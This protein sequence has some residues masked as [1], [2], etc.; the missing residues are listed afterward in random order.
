[1]A[2]VDECLR[3]LHANPSDRPVRRTMAGALASAGRPAQA[4]RVLE[5][6]LGEDPRDLAAWREKAR[7]QRASGDVEG[8][9]ASLR[10]ITELSPDDR[11]AW[12]ELYQLHDLRGDL[13]GA[14]LALRRVTDGGDS[15]LPEVPIAEL[16]LAQG[17]L[18]ERL[19]RWEEAEA[20]LGRIPPESPQA[21]RASLHRAR[22]ACARGDA[23]AAM[24]HLAPWV[25]RIGSIDTAERSGFRALYA[26]LLEHAGRPEEAQQVYDA[27]CTEDPS[28]AEA[29]E[30]A[31]RLRIAAGL[32]P[33][34]REIAR[35]ASGR[36][37]I[38]EA[39]ALLWAEAESGSGDLPSAQSVV[40]SALERFPRSVPL[41]LRLGEI[42]GARSDWRLASE[43]YSTALEIGGP[44]GDLLL[45]L[46]TAREKAGDA[47]G[48][49]AAY[50]QASSLAPT[51][52]RAWT[53][54]GSLL[55]ATGRPEEAAAA[56]DRALATDPECDAARE[57]KKAAERD[58]RMR[59]IEA[60]A[61]AALR[62]EGRRRTPV[63]KH[64]LFV[65]LHV[66]FDLLDPVL[67]AMARA[68][69]L[70][71]ASLSAEAIDQLEQ[72]TVALVEAAAEADRLPNEGGTWSLADVAWLSDP[73]ETLAALQRK[74]AY[75]QAV[76]GM[77]LRPE[78]LS[79][80]PALEEVARRALADGSVEDGVFALV[81]RYRVG[82]FHARIIQAVERASATPRA[83]LPTVELAGEAEPAAE[84]LPRASEPVGAPFPPGGATTV[85]AAP[86]RRGEADPGRPIRT[87]KG[88]PKGAPPS[89]YA[90]RIA[91]SDAGRAHCLGCGG[92]ATLRHACGGTL[93]D[94]C[95]HQFS[96]C[97][98]C[99]EG[100][101]LPPE[102][103]RSARGRPSRERVAPTPPRRSAGPVLGT[104]AHA[105]ARTDPPSAPARSP[106]PRTPVAD[107]PTA[108]PAI[109][110]P[111]GGTKPT[112]RAVS[113]PPPPAPPQEA[114]YDGG[115]ERPV[116]RP[117]RERVDDEPR[118]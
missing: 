59:R 94:L 29:L 52:V 32:H 9:V 3:R 35:A 18:A 79:L 44:T 74:F 45:A 43:A 78:N 86:I 23:A 107:K 46:G 109:P 19:E 4:L 77:E 39:L 40:A 71:V 82:L 108:G 64:D 37:P 50:D 84:P 106:T 73:A 49:L 89:G 88:W 1:M 118:L 20:A 26:S 116:P 68:P 97:P 113:P 5:E 54:R 99:G 22:A 76:L 80:T 53:R 115:P 25:D 85:L 75:V 15:P 117:R 103:G 10:A 100:L 24:G 28:S 69:S 21:A 27:W 105:N 81:L 60:L 92:A 70:D 98:K 38:S 56:F 104:V 62:E 65:T 36:T 33:Q 110:T 87:P 90:H 12:L 13:E 91:G 51:D 66:P 57:G 47:A 95:A 63:T 114:P 102:F 30:G 101:S 34:A 58:A 111:R 42:A 112:G 16:W 96:R 31:V 6:L 14:Y 8:L 61:L 67:A 83:P 2:V 11:L 7:I 72:E 17:T 41:R 48:A 55:L 93:C